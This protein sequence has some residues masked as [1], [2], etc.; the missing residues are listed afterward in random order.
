MRYR[1]L[2]STGVHVS[3]LCLGAMMFGIWGNAD[4]DDSI[5]IIRTA[6]DAGV[7]IID[8]ADVYSGGES[9]LI[10]GKAIAGRR[11]DVVVATKFSSPMGSDPNERGASRRWIIRA[12][13]ESLR[14][15]GTEHIDLYQV[16]RPDAT[17][18]LDETLGA[19]T[20]LVRAGKIRYA[21]SSTF[22]PSMIVQAQWV[23]ERR[24]RERFV[25]EQ[26]PYSLLVRGIEA[27]VLPTCETHRMGVLAWSPL[28]GG[29]LSGR[30]HRGAADPT[31]RRM[32]TMPFPSTSAHYDL[33]VPGNQAKLDAA[34]ELAG[35]ADEAGLTLIQ[36]ALA[37]VIAH[38]AITA[39]IIGPRTA[40]HLDDQLSAADIVL[41][42]GVLDR[43]D[44]IV[45]PGTD[46]N[47]TD[48]GYYA[49]VLAEPNRRRRTV[50]HQ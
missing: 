40:E 11:D 9:E 15:L 39:A 37:F 18:D 29:W 42:A 28:A 48:G 34:T 4:H 2:G 27:D 41:D 32:R 13:E 6:L 46:L 43:I 31:S 33:D 1:T 16:H 50:V 7:N 23:A 19:L 36:L 30:W 24:Q 20:D 35:I 17:T 25:C 8:T 45:S 5:G 10:V 38:P 26:P 22:A 12:C 3:S 21:G 14:R 47:P 49:D 44:R